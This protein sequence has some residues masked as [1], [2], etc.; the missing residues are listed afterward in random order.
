MGVGNG[1]GK[2]SLMD[3]F[4][5]VLIMSVVNCLWCMQLC[6]KRGELRK[7]ERELTAQRKDLA[8]WEWTL[9]HRESRCQKQ[10]L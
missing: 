10:E 2:V 4:Y 3:A 6:V 8:R 1:G 5:F 7:K 9:E